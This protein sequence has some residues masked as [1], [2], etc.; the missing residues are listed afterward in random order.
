MGLR[1]ILETLS[2][3]R[4][5]KRRLP[6]RFGGDTVFVSPDAGLSYWRHNLGNVDADLFAFA[7]EFVASGNSVWDVGASLGLFS[8]AAASVAGSSGFVAAVEPDIFC[9]D[10]LQR[11]AMCQANERAK[12]EVIPVAV[13]DFVGISD[14]NVAARG[15]A[16]SYLSASGGNSQAGGVRKTSKIMTVTLDWLL[17]Q[18]PIPNVLKIDVEGSELAV[19]KGGQLCL[20][21]VRPKILVE[22]FLKNVEA[23]TEVLKAAKYTLYDF[24]H[25][26]QG[27]VELAAFN[28]LAIPNK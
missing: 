25:R 24:E 16:A 2:R 28:T 13:S 22:V 12:V 17:E 3:G 6:S 20:S 9:V 18:L 10:L 7:A 1:S 26:E 15:R 23:V 4:V 19:L 21:Q 11:S 27:P 5:V 14:F 8:F